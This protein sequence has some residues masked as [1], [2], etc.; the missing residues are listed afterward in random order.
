MKKAKNTL[1]QLLLLV[2]SKVINSTYKIHE[3]GSISMIFM[4][5]SEKIYH[6]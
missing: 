2:F 6:I 4:D 1:K 3:D 5:A